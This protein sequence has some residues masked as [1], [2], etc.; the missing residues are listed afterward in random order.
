MSL[1]S[2]ILIFRVE[3]CTALASQNTWIVDSLSG[4][5]LFIGINFDIY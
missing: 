5:L 2:I 3:K 1:L 4:L